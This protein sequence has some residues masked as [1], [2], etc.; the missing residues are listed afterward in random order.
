MWVVLLTGLLLAA[1]IWAWPH[2]PEGGL[3]YLFFFGAFLGFYTIATVFAVLSR[4]G[5]ARVR[6]HARR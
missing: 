4:A 1:A 5:D 3:R 2:V 6:R